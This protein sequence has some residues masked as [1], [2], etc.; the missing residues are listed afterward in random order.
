MKISVRVVALDDGPRCRP[1]YHVWTEHDVPWWE[2][3]DLSKYEQWQH[4]R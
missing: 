1:E 2:A 3:E 4:D